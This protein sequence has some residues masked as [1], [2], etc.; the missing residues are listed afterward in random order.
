MK[1]EEARKLQQKRA[2]LLE[3]E[4]EEEEDE[5]VERSKTPP[6]LTVSSSIFIEGIEYRV[7]RQNGNNLSTTAWFPDPNRHNGSL[8]SSA[9]SLTP[10]QQPPSPAG[11]SPSGARG[12]ECRV[13][14]RTAKAE[15]RHQER[16]RGQS[17]EFLAAQQKELSPAE[18]RALEA[19][20]RAMWRAA[21]MKSLEQDALK[22]QMVIAKSK[23]SKKRGTL[24]QL[25]ES[26]SPAPTP[27]PPPLGDGG[28]RVAVS[29]GRLSLPEKKFLY[30]EFAAIPSSKPV[31]EIQTL[32]GRESCKRLGS[33]VR[34]D[35]DG[36]PEPL[37]PHSPSAGQELGLF[38]EER[39]LQQAQHSLETAVPT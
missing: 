7:E 9:E 20:K 3:E 39:K 24:E 21:R 11:M 37:V 27:S 10:E 30:R 16:L 31:Y 17:P 14:V 26:P 22:A 4:E 33:S 6:D 34:Q 38:G 25:A 32:D 23:E 18:R 28:S 2:Q 19:E 8:R 12:G 35:H 5:E 13:P 1:E 15:R 36:T 29:P